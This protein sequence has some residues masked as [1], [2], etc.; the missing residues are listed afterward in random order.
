MLPQSVRVSA[1]GL[2]VLGASLSLYVAV[3]AYRNGLNS[4]YS[5]PLAFTLIGATFALVGLSGG[6][7]TSRRRSLGPWL[8]VAGA[9]GGLAMWPWLVPS[10]VYLLAAAVSLLS[11]KMQREDREGGRRVGRDE[12]S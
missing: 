11:L 10:L 3:D 7:L 1:G 8:L 4:G 5:T 12:A 6:V 9:L 2:A